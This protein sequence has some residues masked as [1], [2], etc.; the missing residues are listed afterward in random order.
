LCVEIRTYEESKGTWREP[1][2]VGQP[3]NK[4]T[5]DLRI[6]RTKERVTNV[7]LKKDTFLEK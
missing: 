4:V 5:K 3:G 1:I 2:A 7:A 6:N